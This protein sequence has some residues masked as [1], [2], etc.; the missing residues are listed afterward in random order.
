[1]PVVAPGEGALVGA[2]YLDASSEPG[3]FGAKER[4]LAEALAASVGPALRNAHRFDEQRV[5]LL[6][7]KRGAAASAPRMLGESPPMRELD[8]LIARVAPGPHTVLV[9]GESGTGKEL[10]ARSIHARSRRARGPFVAEN[11]G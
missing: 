9:E 1:V 2:I 7:A 8:A 11:L 4:A 6:R 3:R 10:V 5:E